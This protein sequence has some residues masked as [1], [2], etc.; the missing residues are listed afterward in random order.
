MS[1][2]YALEATWNDASRV[3]SGISLNISDGAGGNPTQN[4]TSKVLNLLKNSVSV[5]NVDIDGN[6]V[7][8]SVTSSN[9]IN[10]KTTYGAKGDG[11]TPDNMAINNAFLGGN[12][13]IYFPP[14]VYALDAHQL[15]LASNLVIFAD[16]PSV[17]S[18]KLISPPAAGQDPI[19]G[20][21]LTN[22]I[23]KNITFDGNG[24]LT[25]VNG[26]FPGLRPF[27]YIN[28]TNK[29]QIIN[30]KYT[31]FDTCAFLF[32]I[33]PNWVANYNSI[34]RSQANTYNNSGITVSGGVGFESFN[35]QAIGNYSEKTQ[36]ALNT[37]YSIVSF[38]EIVGW[39][40]SSGINCSQADSCHDNIIAFN[41]AHNCNQ[42]PDV[43]GYYMAGIE[44]WGPNSLIIGNTCYNTIGSGIDNG[45]HSCTIISN[46]CYN[47]G[48]SGN[49]GTGIYLIYQ[50]ATYFAY[51]CIL[52]DNFTYDTR[53]GAARFQAYGIRMQVDTGTGLPPS[54]ITGVVMG[55]NMSYNNITADYYLNQ[56][57]LRNPG[58]PTF[59]T[60]GSIP[61]ASTSGVLTQDN[62]MLFWDSVNKRLGVGINTPSHTGHFRNDGPGDNTV[63]MIENLYGAALAY[64][65]FRAR[66]NS[67]E[68]I[69]LA[70]NSFDP[71]AYFVW[72]GT[73]N[74]IFYSQATSSGMLF[75]TGGA[76]N[77]LCLTNDGNYGLG[78]TSFGTNAIGVL[79]IAN[80][81]PPASSP[82]GIGQLYVE[83][84]VLKY[85]GS[86]GTVTSVASA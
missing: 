71:S 85:R 64:A 57:T 4:I 47:N 3:Y 52:D 12:K 20:A 23:F 13:S 62:S 79:S 7:C 2:I 36:I 63:L 51:D 10:V 40:C 28:T 14:G 11:V 53:V 31:G 37:S 76:N 80:G 38:N 67:G 33:T 82:A 1:F 24:M 78:T 61:F 56:A 50:D 86:A 66:S 75:R 35:G 65:E 26:H 19:Y 59:L 32:N 77:R 81:T 17:V 42:S 25:V 55:T 30:C 8:N 54:L 5:F 48:Y 29:P 60:S 9:P 46:H 43:F 83:A 73:G 49:V 44:N 41:K 72:T 6:I 70:G 45:G 39:G 21:G 84:G 34:I 27:I 58:T 74:I 68:F 16:D 18:L 15:N 69:T 22:V